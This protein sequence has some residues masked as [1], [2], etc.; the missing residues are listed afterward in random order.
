MAA[1]PGW[2]DGGGGG[3]V[4]QQIT[5][6][7]AAALC[8]LLLLAQLPQPVV[9]IFE[10][11]A[12]TFDWYKQYVGRPL[13]AAFLPG[14]ERVFVSTQQQLLASLQ[15]QSGSVVWRR[16]H[17]PQ[18]T[19]EGMLALPSPALL[20]SMSSAGKVVRAWDTLEGS[21]RCVLGGG[22]GDG[23]VCR[24]VVM[25]ITGAWCSRHPLT[26]TPPTPHMKVGGCGVSR[27][28]GRWTGQ[29]R[30]SGARG[31]AAAGQQVSRCGRRC[32]RHNQGAGCAVQGWMARAACVPVVGAG[33]CC[34]A[35]RPIV[36]R[37]TNTLAAAADCPAAPMTIAAAGR[38]QG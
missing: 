36:A 33:T 9:A 24:R 31:A 27:R 5:A 18:D 35:P 30:R 38:R 11:Q 7:A 13:S 34:S 25:A 26:S 17:T 16:K 4:P 37:V 3:R 10:D 12:G 15:A 23:C 32:W 19:L 1:P 6:P 8:V 28:A 22:G 29:H 21:F 2:R 20:L 14:K